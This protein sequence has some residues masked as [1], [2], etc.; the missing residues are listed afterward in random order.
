MNRGSSCGPDSPG[1]RQEVPHQMQHRGFHSGYRGGLPLRM[2]AARASWWT[3]TAAPPASG[4]AAIT[5]IAGAA[6]VLL[7]L[8][9]ARTT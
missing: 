6:L 2:A 9:H 5:R 1:E 4:A 3:S 7:L 8:E